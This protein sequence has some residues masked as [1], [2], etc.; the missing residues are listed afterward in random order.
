MQNIDHSEIVNA[1]QWADI[2][3]LSMRCTERALPHEDDQSTAKLLPKSVQPALVDGIEAYLMSRGCYS[4]ITE[5]NWNSC[6]SS[7]PR[8]Q[9]KHAP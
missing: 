1:W 3:C 5:A 9:L 8:P 2:S 4:L 7:S 6:S